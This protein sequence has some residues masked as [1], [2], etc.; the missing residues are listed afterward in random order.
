MEVKTISVLGAGIMG[1]GIAQV[2]ATAGYRTVL[3]DISEE[4]LGKAQTQTSENLQKGVE[5]KKITREQWEL[6]VSCLEYSTG[7]SKAATSDF[8]IEAAPEK[9]ELKIELFTRLHQIAPSH[10]IFASNTSAL[11]ITEMAAA[12]RRPS[13]FIGMHFFNPVHKMKLV[14]EFFDIHNVSIMSN[15]NWTI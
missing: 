12:S 15:C 11:S 4:M 13:Q 2:S 3:Y 7:F 14:I 5:L 6:A 8:I 10:T 1:S 9:I